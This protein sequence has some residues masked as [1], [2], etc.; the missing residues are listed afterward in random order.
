M[1]SGL[2]PGVRGAQAGVLVAATRQ[3][4]TIRGKAPGV[5]RSL[6]QRVRG[7]LM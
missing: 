2:N 4:H 7:R 6:E 3:G 5:A 1:K